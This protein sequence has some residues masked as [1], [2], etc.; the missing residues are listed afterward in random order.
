MA[1]AAVWAAL[2]DHDKVCV[3]Q[4]APSVRVTVGE[5]FGLPPGTNLTK[6]LY[7]ALRRLGFHAVFDTN[8][9]ADVT[10]VEEANDIGTA[11]LRIDLMAAL[12]R[13]PLAQREALLLVSVEQFSYA[14]CAEALGI[15][16]GTVMSRLAR[17]RERLRQ[18]MA[19]N[20][21]PHAARLRVV[22]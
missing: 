22:K 16:I 1:R 9:S 4:I 7:S 13:L 18:I 12:A 2:N 5:A 8:F 3:V 20:A 21:D 6:K 14:E 10:I 15:P 11:W 17:G 19:G